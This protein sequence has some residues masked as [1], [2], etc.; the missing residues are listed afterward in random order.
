MMTARDWED[1]LGT[2]YGFIQDLA[3]NGQPIPDRVLDFLE[4]RSADLGLEV[5]RLIQLVGVAA[6]RAAK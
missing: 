3:L 6:L 1:E 5:D 4:S 2:A